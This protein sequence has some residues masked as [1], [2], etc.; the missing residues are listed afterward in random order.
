M[1]GGT[2]QGHHL[3]RARQMTLGGWLR[4]FAGSF[5][6]NLSADQRLDE[7][8][9]NPPNLRTYDESSSTEPLSAE[10]S[11]EILPSALNLALANSPTTVTQA[12]EQP[13]VRRSTR[14]RKMVQKY[15]T[16]PLILLFALHFSILNTLY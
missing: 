8:E 10:F 11:A 5:A 3:R 15:G 2:L 1:F 13:E 16:L 9:Q 7:P 14:V 12:S 4:S 6:Q